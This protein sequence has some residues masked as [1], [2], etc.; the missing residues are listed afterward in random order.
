M[1]SSSWSKRLHDGIEIISNT[2]CRDGKAM[3]IIYSAA[4]R[5]RQGRLN[6]WQRRL[7]VD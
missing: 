6:R 7:E 4:H 1:D 2:E 3:S 5:T